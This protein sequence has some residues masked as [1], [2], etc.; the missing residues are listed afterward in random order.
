M[1]VVLRVAVGLRFAGHGGLWYRWCARKRPA[2]LGGVEG[3]W[4]IR[5]ARGGD[6][7]TWSAD[8]GGSGGVMW[9]SRA[10]NYLER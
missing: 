3:W 6:V 8:R 4:G 9:R 7:Y 2:V 5:R 1:S 10:V